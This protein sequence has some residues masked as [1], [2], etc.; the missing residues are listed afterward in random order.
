MDD[1]YDQVELETHEEWAHRI[2]AERARKE[3]AELLRASDY[4][5]MEDYPADEGTRVKYAEYRQAL[6]DITAQPG[7][8]YNV[9]WPEN[10]NKSLAR[11]L[12]ELVYEALR[13]AGGF[14]PSRLPANRVTPRDLW[15]ALS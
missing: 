14:Y 5:M 9:E 15:A 12:S 13:V 11:G 2:L 1:I 3:R 8:P 6:R 4:I 7:F 10:L